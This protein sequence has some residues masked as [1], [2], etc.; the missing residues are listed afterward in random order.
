[1]T[2]QSTGKVLFVK[3]IYLSCNGGGQNPASVDS[4]YTHPTP[5][6]GLSNLGLII[7]VLLL[8]ATATWVMIRRRGQVAA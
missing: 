8:V 3:T 7:L 5:A 2:E 1:M 6:P 4:L